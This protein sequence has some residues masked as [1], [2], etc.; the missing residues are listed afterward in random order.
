M[1]IWVVGRLMLLP[2]LLLDL[3]HPNHQILGT[4]DSSDIVDSPAAG[5][6]PDMVDTQ[7]SPGTPL[8]RLSSNG[9]LWRYDQPCYSC[10]TGVVHAGVVLAL[11]HHSLV[12]SGMYQAVEMEAVVLSGS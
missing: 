3:V 8:Q 2:L 10:N 6:T 5:N 4:E 1:T 11:P 12:V 9:N 7:S